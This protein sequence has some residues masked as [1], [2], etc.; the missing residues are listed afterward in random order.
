MT[1]RGH[2]SKSLIIYYLLWDQVL[3]CFVLFGLNSESKQVLGRRF[4]SE[5][6]IYV[7]YSFFN[8]FSSLSCR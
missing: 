3:I 2:Y 7:C 1:T 4:E 6:V 8:F 5:M